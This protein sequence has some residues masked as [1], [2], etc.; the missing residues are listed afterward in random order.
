MSKKY[1]N[2]AKLCLHCGNET[3]FEIKSEVNEKEHDFAYDD[4]GREIP[5]ITFFSTYTLYKC[6]VC[7]KVTLT[8]L[9]YNDQEI[10]PD[11]SHAEYKETL[12]PVRTGELSLVPD[13]IKNAYESALKTKNVDNVMCV[14]GLRRTL[15]IL[16]REHGE[17][18][19]SL[20]SRL[21]NLS[22]RGIIPEVLDDA[23][24]LIRM[25]GN[26]AAHEDV[27]FDNYV[28]NYMIKFTRII[29]EYVYVIPKEIERM[30]SRFEEK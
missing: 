23:S 2:K 9:E 17:V 21:N 14:I 27:E 6:P 5:V 18:K 10:W 19:G 24:H 26:S 8:S 3:I 28:V 25:I 30:Q 1:S 16:C 11:G 7:F 13:K 15:D 29:L 22:E 4:Y 12:Y 20:H